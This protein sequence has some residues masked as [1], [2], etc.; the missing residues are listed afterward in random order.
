M[1]LLQVI[2]WSMAVLGLTIILLNCTCYIPLC[3][4]PVCPPVTVIYLCVCSHRG[5]FLLITAYIMCAMLTSA[6]LLV[7]SCTFI[8][9]I[10][11]VPYVLAYLL[12]SS[13]L[14][15]GAPCYVLSYPLSCLLCCGCCYWCISITNIIIPCIITIIKYNLDCLVCVTYLI[16]ASAFMSLVTC[17]PYLLFHFIILKICKVTGEFT[18]WFVLVLWIVF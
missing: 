14:L 15:F 7:G 12:I 1:I 8:L 16:L 18:L 17:G 6:W 10:L 4:V 9:G 2:L 5:Y 11:Q 13:C 3:C